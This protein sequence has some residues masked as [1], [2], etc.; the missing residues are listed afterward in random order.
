MLKRNKKLASR[1]LAALMA[2]ACVLTLL[3]GAAMA[4]GE[5]DGGKM[6]VD[7]TATLEDDGTY[8]IELS[9]YATGTTTTVTT[10]EAVPYDIVLVLDQSGSMSNRFGS[11]RTTKLDALKTAARD[12]VQNIQEDAEKNDVDHRVAVVGFASTREWHS[13]S[14]WWPGYYEYGNTE[15]L[16]TSSVVNYEDA[17]SSDY[18]N[19]LV[20]ANS[21]G[22]VNTRLTSAINRLEAS[23]DTY[24]EYGLDMA[25]QI[26]ENNSIAGD[27]NRGRL[28]VMFTDGYTAPSGTNNIDYSMSD[29]A[30][31][32]AKVS[33]T[34]YGA[35]VYT[36]WYLF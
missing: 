14:W 15:I 29:R 18:R 13:G 8:T 7:K 28:V 2:L 4:A 30:I 9:A 3:P 26:F 21:N 27:S 10:E 25:N 11:G 31:G 35:T 34:D 32:N 6:V 36:S 20:S 23:G 1:L 5:D 22:S 12:F 16:S 24:S 19:A 17:D 33:K